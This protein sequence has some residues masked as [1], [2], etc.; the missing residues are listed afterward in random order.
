MVI[1]LETEQKPRDPARLANFGAN[2]ELSVGVD[3]VLVADHNIRQLFGH[4]VEL[5]QL[6]A[7]AAV[8]DGVVLDGVVDV[9]DLA[10]GVNVSKEKPQ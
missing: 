7:Q 8:V 3:A 4:G 6:Q 10:W 5:R 9:R 2:V 1:T